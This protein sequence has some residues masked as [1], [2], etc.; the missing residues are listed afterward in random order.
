MQIQIKSLEVKNCGPLRD[1]IIDFTT[2]N[3]PRPVT[4]LGGANGSGKTTVLELIFA[5]TRLLAYKDIPSDWSQHEGMHILTRA[6]EA[7]LNLSVDNRNLTISYGQLIPSNQGESISFVFS[8][9]NEELIEYGDR[10]YQIRGLMDEQKEEKVGDVTSN[11]DSTYLPSIL[12]FP[13]YRR[14]QS[15][16]GRQITR[17]DV[18]YQWT[19]R[20]DIVRSFEGSLDSYLVWLD[21]A[22]P[23]SFAEVKQF[24][25]QTVLVGKVIDGVNRP[26]LATMIKLADGQT[27]RLDELSSGEQNLLIIM[28]ELRRRLLP[29]SIVL[30][31]EI[32]NSLHPAFQH[33]LA[34]ALLKLQQ[35][36]PFQLIVT[37]HAPSFLDAFGAESALLLT[38]F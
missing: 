25:N 3:T 29:G 22:H 10:A 28:L 27:H 8:F 12:Y 37:T 6:K 17:E 2:N 23:E 4:I 30:I 9:G 26:E 21:Y 11:K 35:Q 16:K 18:L 32:E 14:L 1:V 36:V 33:L 34:E 31:D 7:R 38:E 15:I 13:D 5:L 24:L 20:Y 19:Y